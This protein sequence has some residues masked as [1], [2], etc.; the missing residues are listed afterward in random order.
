MNILGDLTFKIYSQPLH[1]KMILGQAEIEDQQ[2]IFEPDGQQSDAYE[3]PC[4][5]V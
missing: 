5:A 4:K 1:L 3:G 2:V